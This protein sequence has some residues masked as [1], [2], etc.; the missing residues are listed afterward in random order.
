VL[1]QNYETEISL[2]NLNE[3]TNILDQPQCLLGGW[4]V[5]LTINSDFKK[6]HGREYQGSRDIDLGFHIDKNLNECSL[7]ESQFFRTVNILDR[8]GFELISQRFSK[9]Y[10][11]ETRK[12]LDVETAKKTPQAFMFYHFIDPIVD[13]QHSLF[14][15]ICGFAPIDEPL[16]TEVFVNK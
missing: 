2:G 11:T 16:L 3:I 5:Y 1:Y 12:L 9:C 13:Y 15:Q 6:T 10:H 7:R 8:S 4:A 14:E